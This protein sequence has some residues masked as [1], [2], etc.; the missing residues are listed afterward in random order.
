MK[1]FL[2]KLQEKI[3]VP[4]YVG[5][6]AYRES[7]LSR[8]RDVDILISKRDFKKLRKNI[9]IKFASGTE[10][11]T[12]GKFEFEEEIIHFH[13]V[14]RKYFAHFKFLLRGPKEFVDFIMK[15]SLDRNNT[16]ITHFGFV[17]N[18]MKKRISNMKLEGLL[19]SSDEI[20][21]LKS[22]K[23]ICERLGIKK[24]TKEMRRN[25]DAKKLLQEY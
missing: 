16:Y 2:K 7:D 21:T 25:F 23:E 22:E 9:K 20:I 14:Q 18:P 11:V 19:S 6:S 8:V 15:Y 5:G 24:I 12:Y 1:S 4:F 13:A 3:E 17:K 10:L